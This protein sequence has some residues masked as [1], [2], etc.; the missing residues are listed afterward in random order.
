MKKI[1]LFK[2]PTCGPCKLFGPMVKQAAETI[3]AE[4]VEIDVSTDEG[5]EFASKNGIH[6]SGCAWYE[7]DGEV[8]LKWEQPVPAD[9]LVSD[10]NSL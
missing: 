10:I 9:K 4:Y 2:S 5:Y 6:R 7:V 1:I 3:G 8:K